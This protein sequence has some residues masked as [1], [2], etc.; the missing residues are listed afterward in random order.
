MWLYGFAK[1]LVSP[2][3]RTM[4]RIRVEGLEHIPT[5]GGVI[6]C[7]NHFNGHDPL[8]TGIVS[9]RPVSFMAKEEI[10]KWPLVGFLARGVGAFPVKRGAADR[11]SLKKALEVLANGGC[12]GIFPE[13]T[14]SRTGQLRKAEPGTAYIALKAGVP[15]IP[16][17]ISG[18]YKLF[19]PIIVRFG[20]AV[21]LDRF[22]GAKLS[23][24]SLDLAGQEIM[25]A[26]GRL[27][28]PPVALPVASGQD[29]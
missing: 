15:V 7:G 14:R 9:P 22:K 17:G 26:I 29:D 13:G 10:F 6:L 20:P 12:F 19:S 11:S 23:G 5:E 28:V 25:A 1:A 8:V 3:Y 21:N 24:E 18:T 2:I 27:L 16:F 4:F